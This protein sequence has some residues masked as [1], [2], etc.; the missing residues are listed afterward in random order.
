MRLT[1]ECPKC[2]GT[3]WRIYISRN[4]IECHDCLTKYPIPETKQLKVEHQR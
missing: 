4:L 2:G 3:T 1:H